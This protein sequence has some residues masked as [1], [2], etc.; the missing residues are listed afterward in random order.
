M[1]LPYSF[2]RNP[3]LTRQILT[4]DGRVE[5]LPIGALRVPPPVGLRQAECA[6]GAGLCLWEGICWIGAAGLTICTGA[7]IPIVCIAVGAGVGYGI[8]QLTICLSGATPQEEWDKGVEDI[9]DWVAAAEAECLLLE[10][11]QEIADCSK[12]V[13]A[14][15]WKA[16]L[17][18]RKKLG[19]GPGPDPTQPPNPTEM[20]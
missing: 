8:Y 16:F 13:Q 6:V 3:L 5:E 1:S 12:A 10:T 15:A 2:N 17:E 19:L 4:P 14:A 18:L 7:I 11:E 20:N 9:R